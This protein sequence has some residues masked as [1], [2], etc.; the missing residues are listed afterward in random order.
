MLP[1]WRSPERIRRGTSD[2]RRLSGSVATSAR[3]RAIPT[4]AFLRSADLWG[5][6]GRSPSPARRA[7]R[8]VSWLDDISVRQVSRATA[9]KTLPSAAR[10]VGGRAIAGKPFDLSVVKLPDD[11]GDRRQVAPQRGAL[12][13]APSSALPVPLRD[14]RSSI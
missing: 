4:G 7:I 1:P 3:G 5:S 11:E 6:R 8:R 10:N 14:P 2:L 13:R 9:R 12:P